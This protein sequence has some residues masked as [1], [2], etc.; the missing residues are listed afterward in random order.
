[1]VEG[2]KMR[3]KIVSNNIAIIFI[4]MLLLLTSFITI[5]PETVKAGSDDD[6]AYEL[7]R[8]ILAYPSTLISV[9]YTDSDHAGTRQAIVLSEL[10]LMKPT[11]GSTF[12]LL[13]TGIAGA[14]PVTTNEQNPG[15]ERG[16][17]FRTRTWW[18]SWRDNQYGPPYDTAVLTM[19]LQ[20]PPFMHYIY[21]DFQF[22]SSEYPEYVGT[23]YNDKFEVT[24]NSPSKGVS[25]YVCDVN[26]GNFVLDSH[27][28]PGTGF[29]IF[30]RSGNPE[31]VDIVDT[32]PRT[33]GADAGAT[34]LVTRGGESHPVSPNEII[35]VTF[36]IRD[37]GD[38][39]FDSAVFIDNLVFAGEARAEIVARKTV[40]DLNGELCEP[41]DI[42]EYTIT[43][44]NTGDADQIEK[45]G[46]EFQD[47]IPENA[48]Y[49]LG[50]ATA[51]SGTVAY[52]A[53]NN[54]I[55]WNGNILAQSSVVIRFRVTVD[56]NCKDGTVISNQGMVFWDKN[57]DG[58]NDAIEYTHD[59]SVGI[60]Y[61]PA[62]TNITVS[63]FEEPSNLTEYFSDDTPGC[64]AKQVY[65]MYEWF[66]TT[67]S[68]LRSSFKV[69]SSYH[70][71]KPQSFK[72]KIRSTSEN[73]YWNYNLSWL[74][75]DLK[76]WEIWFKCGNASEDADLFL[77]FKNQ[78]N[79]DI[80][81]IKFEYVQQGTDYLTD[82]L[83]EIY[84][85]NPNTGWDRLNSDLYGG[86]LYNGWYKLVIE[87]HGTNYINY[88]LY[89]SDEILTDFKQTG[90]LSTSLSD[91]KEIIWNST[92]NPVV[93]PMFFWDEHTIRLT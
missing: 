84:Y 93:C 41:N 82:W 66:N 10:G 91:L 27:D 52:D 38:N 57:G 1:M 18:G 30:A 45:P 28:I 12:A 19:Q 23:H 76:S 14:N 31:G 20:V 7:A 61:K 8:A 78:N 46:D 42:L 9:S 17:W 83:A 58:N 65:R 24:V 13:S 36:S 72:T 26:S 21:Y 92:K 88:S 35:T 4:V 54:M 90:T 68:D 43:I 87:K 67:T 62:P 3:K 79:Q 89:N 34:A 47:M 69:A 22:F 86:Y 74:E 15:N 60:E 32:T 33:P 2:N 48:T 5:N 25:T 70:Y 77:T 63:V 64:A 51:T 50:S 44:S 81:K 40:Q 49:V 37:V 55:T 71:D 56:S 85:Y 11:N 53:V 80:A 6:F 75:K 16:T 59:P 29:D 73:L 39:Q